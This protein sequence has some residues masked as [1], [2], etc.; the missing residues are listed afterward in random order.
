MRTVLHQRKG[1][2]SIFDTTPR[3]I[4]WKAMDE[5]RAAILQVHDSTSLPNSVART[6]CSAVTCAMRLLNNSENAR[7]RASMS[8]GGAIESMAAMKKLYSKFKDAKTKVT[9]KVNELRGKA[10]DKAD[11]IKGKAQDKV[12]EMKGKAQDKVDE[13][14]DTVNREKPTTEDS[15]PQ[16]IEMRT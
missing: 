6:T 1:D 2:V 16:E 14:N 7:F 13:A 5:A 9:D 4:L 3:D 11:E 12:D 10:Q 8:G 15:Q